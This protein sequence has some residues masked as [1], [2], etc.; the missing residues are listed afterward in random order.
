MISGPGWTCPGTS[1][2]VQISRARSPPYQPIR[3]ART[4][5]PGAVVD[6]NSRNEVPGGTSVR[7]VNP[8]SWYRRAGR[9]IRQSGSSGWG[10]TVLTVRGVRVA[11][12]WLAAGGPAVGGAA[13][14]VIAVRAT[15]DVSRAAR[16][17][18]MAEA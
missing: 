7:S 4:R 17:S 2:E 3:N 14:H 18:L 8:A 6:T 5:K 12:G 16:I 11:A 9:V 15:H 13:V 1:G 10:R